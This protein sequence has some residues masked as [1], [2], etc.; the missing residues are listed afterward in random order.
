MK[1]GI[2]GVSI[3][4]LAMGCAGCP[5]ARPIDPGGVDDAQTAEEAKRGTPCALAGERLSKVCPKVWRSAAYWSS[6]CGGASDAGESPCPVR[7]SRAKDCVEAE[8]I[9]KGCGQ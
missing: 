9:A 4:L 7:L 6:F 5:S 3:V 8:A 1:L 2:A